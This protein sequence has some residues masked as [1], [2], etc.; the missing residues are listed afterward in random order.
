MNAYTPMLSAD[1][2]RTVDEIGERQALLKKAVTD[3]RD[4]PRAMMIFDSIRRNPPRLVDRTATYVIT[5]DEWSEY[6]GQR[7]DRL[8][9]IYGEYWTRHRDTAMVAEDWSDFD[10]FMAYPTVQGAIDEVLNPAEPVE[11]TPIF[12]MMMADVIDAMRPRSAWGMA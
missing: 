5:R 1:I 10:A 6:T 4:D 11:P 12:D 8:E 3:W 2:S 7:V 9:G